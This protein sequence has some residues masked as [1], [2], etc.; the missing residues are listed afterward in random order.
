APSVLHVHLAALLEERLD[1]AAEGSVVVRIAQAL[2]P[3]LRGLSRPGCHALG[4]VGIHELDGGNGVT[5]PD[6]HQPGALLAQGAHEENKPTQNEVKANRRQVSS[7]PARD[8]LTCQKSRLEEQSAEFAPEP[9]VRVRE[10]LCSFANEVQPRMHFV[11]EPL[12]AAAAEL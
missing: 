7:A 6:L 5:G 2:F 4:A 3:L 12:T 1:E 10:V 9:G 8:E 11:L